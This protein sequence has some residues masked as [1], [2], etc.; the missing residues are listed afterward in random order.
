[1]ASTQARDGLRHGRDRRASRRRGA[2]HRRYSARP[3]RGVGARRGAGDARRPAGLDG[4]AETTMADPSARASVSWRRSGPSGSRP[5]A[6]VFAVGCGCLHR[7]ARGGVGAL[8]QARRAAGVT[9]SRIRQ[10]AH[11]LHRE[12][13]GRRV[14][15][16]VLVAEPD[17]ASRASNVPPGSIAET[18]AESPEF[19]LLVDAIFRPIF[20][21]QGSF[22]EVERHL[23]DPIIDLSRWILEPIDPS[24]ARPLPAA[25]SGPAGWRGGDPLQVAG[26]DEVAAPLATESMLAATGSARVTRYDPAAHGML[27]VLHQASRHEPPAGATVRA[28]AG[29]DADREPHRRGA[30]GESLPGENLSAATDGSGAA[31]Q[32]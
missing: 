28:A 8:A 21:V 7:R 1:M 31:A 30:S 24:G 16:L 4:F 32:P 10:T 11:R 19:C 20:G 26:L 3:T 25:P 22:D 27:E 2:R 17:C 13:A 29:R 9:A 12:F 23:L 14:R 15:P 18:L 5:I 6:G